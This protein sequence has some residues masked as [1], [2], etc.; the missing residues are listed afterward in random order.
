VLIGTQTQQKF[1][2][3][4][5]AAPKK[6]GGNG[7]QAGKKRIVREQLVRR[8]TRVGPKKQVLGEKNRGREQFGPTGRGAT[9]EK[10]GKKTR[11]KKKKKGGEVPQRSHIQ[12]VVFHLLERKKRGGVSSLKIHYSGRLERKTLLRK[13]AAGISERGR[14][15]VSP[16]D[17]RGGE[18]P[19]GG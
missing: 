10:T 13:R 12:R 16:Q 14:F 5:K 15:T 7:A 1:A 11:K 4:K 19:G 9:R 17:P 3:G 8:T 18:K 2:W 6:G